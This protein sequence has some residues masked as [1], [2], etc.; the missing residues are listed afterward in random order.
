MWYLINAD[1]KKLDSIYV[2]LANPLYF[3]DTPF[4]VAYSLYI[5]AL[6]I[7]KCKENGSHLDFN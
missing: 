2:D 4:H 6:V 7:Y 5:K 1:K 3:S